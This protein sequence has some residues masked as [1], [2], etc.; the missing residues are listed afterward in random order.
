MSRHYSRRYSRRRKNSSSDGIFGVAIIFA[1]IAYSY[2]IE[3]NQALTYAVT[4]GL[5]VLS[6]IVIKEIAVRS[7]KRRK[8]QLFG[9]DV[10]A[11]TGLRFERYVAAWLK[12][13]G[14]IGVRLT[15]H[16]DLGVDIIAR[17]DGITW[18]VQVKRCNGMVKAAAVRQ[19]VTA[20]KH[21]KCDQAMVVTN[22]I[23][24][25]PAIQLAKSNDCVLVDRVGQHSVT[26]R[27]GTPS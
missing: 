13:Q 1:L 4:A 21:Y 20:L 11:M 7:W 15:E 2:K 14:Y 10:S 3:P 19:V 22:G 27:K 16:Y 12:K 26:R 18:G 23:Y 5:V 17:K 24:S 6:L 9:P 8:F 25:R